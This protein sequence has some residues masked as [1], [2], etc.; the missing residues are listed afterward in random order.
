M[1]EACTVQLAL[2]LTSSH[3]EMV[4][5]VMSCNYSQLSRRW[6][7]AA[8]PFT[9]KVYAACGGFRDGPA[10]LRPGFVSGGAGITSWS[11]VS[12]WV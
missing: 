8:A 10:P 1:V 6:L 9:I 2:R 4:H 5:L 7:G 3:V 12:G 11:E